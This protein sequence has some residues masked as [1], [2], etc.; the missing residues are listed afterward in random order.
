[1]S[2]SL[3]TLWTLA[4]AAMLAASTRAMAGPPLARSAA[5]MNPVLG[6]NSDFPDSTVV[7]PFDAT[8]ART[9]Y[10]TLSWTGDANFTPQWFFYDQTGELLTQVNR[11]IL[12][13]GGTD[14]VDITRVS[15]RV[16]SSGELVDTG[17]VQSFAGR[18][19]F[20]VVTAADQ[21]Y[22][23]GSWTIANAAT[24]A[25][26]G[27][28]AAGFGAI[29]ALVSA[30]AITGTTFNPASLQDGLLVILGLN[31]TD[32]GSVTSLTNGNAPR[33]GQVI[34]DVTVEL[35]G[36]QGDGIIAT[37]VFPQSGS[38]LFSSLKG[39]FPGSTLNSSATILSYADEASGYS[40][41]PWDGDGD[42]GVSVIGWYGQTLGPY[43]TGQSLRTLP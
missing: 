3:R 38:T 41:G 15:N 21:P 20:V 1:M 29:G 19:G 40:G 14:V 34:M 24:N 27:G 33:P 4:L 23:V 6:P 7:M 12:S 18:R 8:G 26:F 36:N 28:A 32:D 25:A 13:A 10:F 42:D 9:S 16:Y 35:R 39:L 17:P 43:G 22:L 5:E 31:P 37:R 30:P 2:R 11:A